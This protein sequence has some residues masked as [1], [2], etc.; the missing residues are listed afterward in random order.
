[1]FFVLVNVLIDNVLLTP[2]GL[3]VP[4]LWSKFAPLLL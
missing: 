1:L 4:H 3:L 2:W